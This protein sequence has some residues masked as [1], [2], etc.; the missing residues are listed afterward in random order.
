[1]KGALNEQLVLKARAH[2]VSH[3]MIGTNIINPRLAKL[4]GLVHF[5]KK[6]SFY[7]VRAS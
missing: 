6:P 7:L 1:M 3:T 5:D 2:Y 4:I